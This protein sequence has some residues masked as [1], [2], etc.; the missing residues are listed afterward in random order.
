MKKREKI[1]I[2]G[3][4]LISFLI[5]SN[6]A[7]AAWSLD[8]IK[9]FGLPK[10]PIINIIFALADWLFTIFAAVSVSAF[11]V[12]GIMYLVSAGNDEMI[13]KSKKY[14]TYSILGVIVGLSGFVIIQA[15]DA[16]LNAIQF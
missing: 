6:F 10:A 9:N 3:M 5:F 1:I 8:N 13:N 7:G 15:A 2:L 4:V 11:L 14:M 12:S 16:M